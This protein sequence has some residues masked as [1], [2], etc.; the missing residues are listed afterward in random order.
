MALV[1]IGGALDATAFEYNRD[2]D[3][4]AAAFVLRQGD[5]AV[6][7][8]PLE[9]YRQCA[10]SVAELEHDLGT[11]GKLGRWLWEHFTSPPDWVRIGGNWPLGDSPPV[12]VTAL[13]VESSRW[14]GTPAEGGGERRMYTHV[15]TR[16]LFGDLL[17]R[18]RAHERAR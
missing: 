13:T 15:D 7:Q 1:W 6:H 17:A 18:L 5:L 10:Y 9:T 8:F 4:D 12:L 11:T 14:T 16:L 2:T 3:P